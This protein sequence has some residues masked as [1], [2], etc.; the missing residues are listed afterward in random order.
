MI[1]FADTSDAQAKSSIY[2]HYVINTAISFDEEPVSRERMVG[3][4]LEVRASS[5]PWLIAE[6]SGKV[7][8]YAYASKWRTRSAYR[9]SVEMSVHL[10]SGVLGK[11]LGSQLYE[12]LFNELEERGV[13]VV[14][15]GIA[16][17][18]E[19]SISL[20]EKFG[21]KKVAHFEQVGF[22]FGKWIDVGFWQ[23]VL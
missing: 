1:R 23:K 19:A 11:G 5:L 15:A 12:V 2:N 10:Q 17:P 22:K 13:H 16:L 21:L 9:F 20:H 7:L 3:R 14:I 6:E 4:I 18:N 8:G